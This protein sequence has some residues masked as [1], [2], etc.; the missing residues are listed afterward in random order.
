M[1]NHV[2][3]DQDMEE[4]LFFE[5]VA[6]HTLLPDDRDCDLGWMPPI[7]DKNHYPMYNTEE[8]LLP[9][10]L[11]EAILSFFIISDC[12]SDV[13]I[14]SFLNLPLL[15]ISFNSSINLFFIEL[16]IMNLFIIKFNIFS[17]YG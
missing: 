8:D 14:L 13:I 15:F 3:E 6:D 11:K 5:I 2:V 16:Y 1:D 12:C 4:S 7:H 9:P 17:S 10:S